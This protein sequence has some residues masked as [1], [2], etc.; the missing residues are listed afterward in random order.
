MSASEV[1]PDTGPEKQDNRNVGYFAD[2][3]SNFIHNTYFEK[4]YLTRIEAL[5]LVSRIT[6]M[7]E[8]DE[9]MRCG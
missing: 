6:L 5:D 8:Q 2:V 7:L 1:K 9:R 3:R 4:E